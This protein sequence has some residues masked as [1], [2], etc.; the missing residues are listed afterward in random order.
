MIEAE[1]AKRL[2]AVPIEQVFQLLMECKAELTVAD[3]DASE[4]HRRWSEASKV[5]EPIQDAIKFLKQ[6]LQDEL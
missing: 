2:Q 1:H 6:R 5:R 3:A 4:A